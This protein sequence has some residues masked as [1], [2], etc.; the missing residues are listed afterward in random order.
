MAKD[1]P[2]SEEAKDFIAKMFICEPPCD[3]Y[4]VCEAC[5]EKDLF[6]AGYNF[7]YRADRVCPMCDA[8]WHAGR[9]YKCDK[10]LPKRSAKI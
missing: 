5:L 2:L 10:H 3:S 7:G 6:L 1:E 4:V 8:L 9:N